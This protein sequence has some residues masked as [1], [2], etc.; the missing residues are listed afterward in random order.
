MKKLLSV[1]LSLGLTMS[2]FGTPA[3]NPP[4]DLNN[5]AVLNDSTITPTPNLAQEAEIISQQLLA[6]D[7]ILKTFEADGVSYVVRSFETYIALY[8]AQNH[9]IIICSVEGELIYGCGVAGET[10][11]F[12]EFVKSATFILDNEE[13]TA[14]L[15]TPLDMNGQKFIVVAIYN[16]QQHIIFAICDPALM[17]LGYD[18]IPE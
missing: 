5:Q 14:R 1:F 9:V 3:P 18:T 6:N 17:S 4:A 11:P 7:T 15:I 10:D 8:N 2:M 13:Y 12:P 16:K